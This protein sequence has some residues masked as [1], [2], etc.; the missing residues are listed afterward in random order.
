MG[1]SG[2]S[3]YKGKGTHTFAK[4]KGTFS[5][6]DKSDKGKVSRSPATTP[7][8]TRLQ[9][10]FYHLQILSFAWS[11]KSLICSKPRYY[12]MFKMLNLDWL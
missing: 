5:A 9:C 6:K 7:S 4:G 3:P 10:K 2:Q 12:H 11:L 8:F 1:L